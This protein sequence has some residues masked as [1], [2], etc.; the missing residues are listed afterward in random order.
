VARPELAADTFTRSVTGGW[1]TADSGQTWTPDDDAADFTVAGG[2]GVIDGLDSGRWITLPVDEP[3]V[4]VAASVAFTAAP[5]ED[6]EYDAS[7]LARYT[8]AGNYYEFA[9]NVT[10]GDG[11]Q[12]MHLDVWRRVATVYELLTSTRLDLAFAA[13]DR[14]QLVGQ[15]AGTRLRAKVWPA[16]TEEPSEWMAEAFDHSHSDSAEAGCAGF[17]FDTTVNPIDF[18]DFA[19]QAVPASAALGPQQIATLV[20]ILQVAADADGGILFETRDALGLSYRPLVSLY[21]QDPA[22]T[23]DAEADSQG[24]IANP[25]APVLDDQAATNDVTVTRTDGSSAR[26]TDPSDIERRGL[27]DTAVELNVA[28]DGQLPGQATWRLH[29]GT[30]P[31]MR[32]PAVTPALNARPGLI[33]G[34]L[35][36]DAGDRIDVTNLPPQHPPNDVTLILQGYAE[37]I[38]PTTWETEVNCSPYG[39]YE[40]GQVAAADGSEDA[41]GQAVDTDWSTLASGIDADDTTLSVATDTSSPLRGLWTVDPDDWDDDLHGGPL[42]IDINGERME[43]TDITGASSPQTFTVVRAANGVVRA[44]DAGSAVHVAHPA[45]VGL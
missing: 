23:L 34:W 7:L 21:N 10:T 18:D 44:H 28:S 14:Y 31:G 16:G 3:D 37:T 40:I 36:L 22:L 15:V 12:V 27:R 17:S 26:A 11:S 6:G 35:P 1:G 24:D 9:I 39:P 4:E 43:V 20:E 19:V 38:R 33:T 29:L 32:Y 30:W 25:F 41:R 8:D 2:V 5:D 45:R 42:L 13:N